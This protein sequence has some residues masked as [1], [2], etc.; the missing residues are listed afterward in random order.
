VSAVRLGIL[1]DLHRTTNVAQRAEFHNEYDFG[2]HSARIARALAWFGEEEVDALIL[3]GDLT[4]TAEPEAMAAVLRECVAELEVP[5][6]AVAG[7]HDVGAGQD[8]LSRAIERPGLDRLLAGSPIGHMIA[9]VR[10]AGLQ[11]E[12]TSGWARSRLVSLPA[13]DAW[14]EEPVVLVSHLPL[15]SRAST[16]AA[17]GMP[18]PGDLLDREDAAALLRGRGA[19]TVVVAGHIHVRDVHTDDGILQLLQG[20][21]I[22]SP[23]EAVLLDVGTD[24]DGVV[25]VTRTARRTS[26]RPVRCE[27]TF[28]D[29]VGSW[30][31]ESAGWEATAGPIAFRDRKALTSRAQ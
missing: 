26:D 1:S 16:V 6:I 14:G 23:F 2:G 9:E 22:E 13:V 28:T 4:H 10:V 29:P 18:Y 11:L 19:P 24:G 20:A 21:M 3:C 7:N 27:P 25:C 30:R 5:V 8:E 17:A 15:L 31:F 12:P